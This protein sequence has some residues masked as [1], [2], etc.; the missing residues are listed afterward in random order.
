[1]VEISDFSSQS[2]ENLDLQQPELARA[3]LYLFPEKVGFTGFWHFTIAFQRD[4][5]DF[6]KLVILGPFSD[7]FQLKT[8][9]TAKVR[10]YSN[11]NVLA[12]TRFA[13]LLVSAVFCALRR[14][15]LWESFLIIPVRA[16]PRLSAT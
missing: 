16:G 2:C 5:G 10:T 1:M 14:P 9:K 4:P 7:T 12:S 8:V 11:L 15:P 3:V 6:L 13:V